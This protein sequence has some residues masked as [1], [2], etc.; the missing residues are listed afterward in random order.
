MR[1]LIL[2][3][4]LALT[5]GSIASAAKIDSGNSSNIFLSLEGKQISAMEAYKS[6][7][8]YECVKK[9]VHYNQRTGKPSLKKAD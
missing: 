8:V 9:E 6:D 5:I 3:T 4:V 1:N 7:V 2:S